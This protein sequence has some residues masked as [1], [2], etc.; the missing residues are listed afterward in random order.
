MPQTAKELSSLASK[1]PFQPDKLNSSDIYA[2]AD[3]DLALE[4]V[5]RDF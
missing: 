2:G 4:P 1:H 5:L 3:R